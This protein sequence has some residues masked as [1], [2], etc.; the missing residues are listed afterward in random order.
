M[1][2]LPLRWC[3]AIGNLGGL[4]IYAISPRRQ[5]LADANLVAAFGERF[6]PAERRAI[7]LAVAR[8]VS[9]LFLELFKLPSLSPEQR[10]RLL[11]MQGQ[12]HLEAALARGKGALVFSAHFGNWEL[13]GAELA[14]MGYETAVVARDASDAET[15]SIINASRGGVGLQ[16]YGRD[17]P[18]AMV[19]H[20]RRNGMLMLLPDQHS[21]E[22]PVQVMFL[23]R[24]AW[25]ARGP[26]ML[27]LRTGC[28]VVPGFCLRKPDDTFLG[29]VLPEVPLPETPDREAA[30]AELMQRIYDV[31]GEQITA[32]PEQWLWFHNRWKEYSPPA[33]AE[34]GPEGGS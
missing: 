6:T 7:R 5:R 33:G 34:A 3:Q 27:A 12:E 14:V 11:E 8:N 9:K 23:G 1:R 26:A 13:G 22:S 32:H 24:P 30:T 29:Y 10:S 4:I 25:C 2:P 18:K 31:I 15:A 20:L 16:V 21:N 28:A 17:Q 19:S